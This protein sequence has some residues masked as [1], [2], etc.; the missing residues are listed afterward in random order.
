MDKLRVLVAEDHED[1]RGELVSV[2]E[3]EFD[4]VGTA[5]N[6]RELADAAL[7]LRP[8]VIVSDMS[9]PRLNGPQAM[10]ELRTG[11]HYIPF[12]FISS[13]EVIVGESASF[14][15]KRDAGSELISAVYSAASGKT[16]LSR[17]YGSKGGLKP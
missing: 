16:Y 9:M 5:A 14:V 6:G 1:M 10:Q 7:L 4:I 11:G 15:H 8:D 12:V 2:L 3:N 13:C 17:T